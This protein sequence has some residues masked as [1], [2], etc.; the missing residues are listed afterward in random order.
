[1]RSAKASF[2]LFV[3][4][5]ALAC[6][7]R[8]DSVGHDPTSATT[9]TNASAMT[10]T[11]TSTSTSTAPT[12]GLAPI[13]TVELP[14]I[15]ASCSKDAD[16]GYLW[17]YLID[18]KCCKG[19]CSPKPASN[20]HVAKIDALCQKLGYEEESCP[21]KKC[22]LSGDVRCVKGQCAIAPP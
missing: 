22:A 12:P 4:I 1:M 21:M 18:G 9:S 10:S 6:P 15:D 5:G 2:V 19:T 8:D 7:R 11:S 20:A 13:A 3:T 14:P 16:C 17:A